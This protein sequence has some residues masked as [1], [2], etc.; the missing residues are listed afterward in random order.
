MTWHHLAAFCIVA[1]MVMGCTWLILRLPDAATGIQ[2][3]NGVI[4]LAGTMVGVVGGVAVGIK[5]ANKEPKNGN[6]H[7]DGVK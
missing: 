2:M 7:G 6:G 3:F 4:Q 1:L 5:I